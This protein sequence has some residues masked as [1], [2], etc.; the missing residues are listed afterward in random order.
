MIFFK[1]IKRCALGTFLLVSSLELNLAA[2]KLSAN[3]ESID[4]VRGFKAANTELRD[5]SLEVSPQEKDKIAYIV[6]TLGNES[7][8]KICKEMGSLNRAGDKI[9]HVHP[10]RFLETIFTNEELKAAIANIKESKLLWGKFKKGLYGSLKDETK[11]KNMKREFILEFAQRVNIDPELIIP[12]IKQ[13]R[14]D[15]LLTI[16]IK[17]VPRSGNS[18]RYDM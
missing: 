7:W 14:W 5:Y 2:G 10:L 16:L 17:N 4:N 3:Q 13:S 8:A 6:T 12:S 15:D 1:I 18:N 11:N 9:V